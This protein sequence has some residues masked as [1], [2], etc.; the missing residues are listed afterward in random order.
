MAEVSIQVPGW[1]L[2]DTDVVTAPVKAAA[3]VSA[4]SPANIDLHLSLGE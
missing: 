4:V 1:L 3:I 2:N